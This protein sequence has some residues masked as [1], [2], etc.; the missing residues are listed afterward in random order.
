[1]KK[2]T[3]LISAFL[4]LMPLGKPLVF[5]TSAFLTSAG[6]MLAASE[7]AYA[8]SAEFYFNRAY[9]KAEEGDHYGAISDYT[10]AL[11]INPRDAE[12]YYNRGFAKGKS[13]DYD[14]AISDYS[15]AI[16]INPRLVDA[17]YNRGNAK[18][19]IGDM[20]GACSDWREASYLGDQD[21]AKWLKE[22]C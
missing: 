20:K 17:Y 22:D 12:A 8:E 16:E 21:A 15:K 9:N 7:K 18:E 5:G 2:R 13:E 6:L 4:A 11:E 19:L 14:G 3:A 1:M 10:R